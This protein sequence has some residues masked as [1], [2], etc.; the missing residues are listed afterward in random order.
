M[1]N[2]E[3]SRTGVHPQI[4]LFLMLSFSPMS[5]SN[6]LVLKMMHHCNAMHWCTYML[7]IFPLSAL[8][9]EYWPKSINMNHS[10]CRA[11]GQWCVATKDVRASDTCVASV[12]VMRVAMM[13]RNEGLQVL[14][15]VLHIFSD[16]SYMF[17]WGMIMA[18]VLGKMV[19]HV[20]LAVLGAFLELGAFPQLVGGDTK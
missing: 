6:L 13:H 16:A 12:V 18:D 2:T 7:C 8:K 14:C 17:T 3:Y 20:P 15:V 19:R 1:L 5:S 9:Y 11:A 4:E 10:S